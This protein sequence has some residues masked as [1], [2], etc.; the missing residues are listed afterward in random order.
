MK[1]PRKSHRKP[2]RTPRHSIELAEFFGIML[3]D[4]GINN[5]WQA[6]ITL[7]AVKDVEYAHFVAD[8]GA[9]LFGITPAVR[10]RKDRQALVVS[11][12]SKSLVEYLVDNGLPRGNKIKGGISIPT[13]IN[14][15]KSFRRSCVRGLVDTDGCL[16]IHNHIVNGKKYRNIGL[17]FSSYSPEFVL[18][19]ARVFEEFGILPHISGW[20]QNLFVYSVVSVEKYLEVFGS[21]NERIQKVY[22]DWRD[23]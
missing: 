14:A 22:R 16:Y 4:G 19:V 10:K 9:R 15:R 6:N 3:G 21:S 2:F 12:S 1:Y 20:G 13:W 11:F 8:L 5:E 7:N 18:E 23:G 17:N